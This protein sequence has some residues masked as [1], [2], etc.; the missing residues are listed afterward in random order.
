MSSLA[1]LSNEARCWSKQL[2]R[3]SQNRQKENEA[4]AFGYPRE[5]VFA[6]LFGLWLSATGAVNDGG[7]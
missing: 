4:T 7:Q 5:R 1:W 3:A 6:G 2:S